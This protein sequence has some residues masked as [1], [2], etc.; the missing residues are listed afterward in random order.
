MEGKKV[1][2]VGH[3]VKSDSQLGRSLVIDLNA[4]IGH[5]YRLID[6]RTIKEIV[7]RNVKY[8]L[9]KRDSDIDELPLPPS[10]IKWDVSKIAVGNRLSHTVYYKFR[11]ENDKERVMVTVPW[12]SN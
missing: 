6:H 1:L 8:I 2:I 10:P 5:N 3:L 7:F 12:D 11:E 4:P 9:G